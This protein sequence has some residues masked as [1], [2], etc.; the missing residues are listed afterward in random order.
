MSVLKLS[1]LYEHK[2]LKSEDMLFPRS[3]PLS[4][5]LHQYTANTKSFRHA[6]YFIQIKTYGQHLGLFCNFLT[7][8]CAKINK[9]VRVLKLN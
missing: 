9:C 3:K 4:L 1:H 6:F 8:E 2:Y 7:A 5:N